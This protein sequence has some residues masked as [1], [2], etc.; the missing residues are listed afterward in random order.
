MMLPSASTIRAYLRPFYSEC[1][2]WFK[3]GFSSNRQ[4]WDRFPAYVQ[5]ALVIVSIVRIRRISALRIRH[6]SILRLAVSV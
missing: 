3:R 2:I 1:P 5:T 4:G 6:L